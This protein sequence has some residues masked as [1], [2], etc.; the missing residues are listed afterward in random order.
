MFNS[1]AIKD[2]KAFS[3]WQPL[4]L[5]PITL[6]Y[7]PNSSGKSSIIHSI[8]LLKQSITRPNV[9][10]GLVANGEY[11]DLGDYSSMVHRHEVDR[12]MS[13]RFSYRPKKK[14]G[15]IESG[16]DVFGKGRRRKYELH[17]RHTEGLEG[18]GFSYLD[19]FDVEVT[20]DADDEVV[21]KTS[22]KSKF[23]GVRS[24]S[25][26]SILSLSKHYGQKSDSV[27]SS[28]ESEIKSSQASKA[29]SASRVFT[30]SGRDA[31]NAAMEY[32]KSRPK[33]T[34]RESD[35]EKVLDSIVFRSDLS[36]A[37]PS[38]T[39]LEGKATPGLAVE[40]F[41][42]M[43]FAMQ[44]LAAELKS[45]FGSITYLGPLRSHPSRFYAPRADQN[46]TVGKQGENVVKF[47]H[48]RGEMTAD[49]NSWFKRFEIPYELEPISIGNQVTGPVVCLQLRDLRTGVLVGPSDVGFGIGQMLPVIVEGLVR[50]DSVICVEQ[51]E[52]HL[53]PRLQAHLANFFAETKDNNQWIVETHSESLLLRI[54]GMIA[55]GFLKKTDVNVLY[56]EPTSEGGE[57][58]QIRLDSEGDFIDPWPDGFFDERLTEK[59][60]G[61]M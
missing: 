1:I 7:G 16:F 56:V 37:T 38:M 8:M 39:Y 18:N 17:Y 24:P 33:S 54:Q 35:L 58:T 41:V 27:S 26:S 25:S 11:V 48:E 45:K 6:I 28:K 50:D 47:I 20:N 9:Q 55:G 2:F 5:A 42:S 60:R 13:F 29:L 53:H 40:S 57:I 31:W 44:S 23:E 52:I 3:G 49:I 14:Q 61:G 19:K 34:V 22:L 36:Y 59:Q 32:L 4:R 12:S 21:F 43:N 30:F 51:P 15:L 46:E 10:G